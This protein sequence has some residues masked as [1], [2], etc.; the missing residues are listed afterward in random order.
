[1]TPGVQFIWLDQDG[2]VVGDSP[3]ILVDRSGVFTLEVVSPDGCR[4]TQHLEV[5][6]GPTYQLPTVITPNGD[7]KNDQLV[8]EFCGELPIGPITLT[9]FNRWGQEVYFSSQY[10][11]SWGGDANGLQLPDGQY[12]YIVVLEG[13]KVKQTLS[14]L[15]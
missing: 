10:D 12:Y 6:L 1:M 14:I 11:H 8:L 5:Q 15:R 2:H 13:F 3:S 9:V 7:G 4:S